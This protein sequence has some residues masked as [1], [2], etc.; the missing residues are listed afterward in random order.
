MNLIGC[1]CEGDERLLVAEF[2]PNE[3]LAKHLFHCKLAIYGLI[4][5]SAGFCL[6]TYLSRVRLEFGCPNK[7]MLGLVVS[8]E[9]DK[10]FCLLRILWRH[11]VLY[12][13]L[14]SVLWEIASSGLTPRTCVS[15][16]HPLTG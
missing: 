8:V 4:V 10:K 15:T 12:A 6:L 13:N 9:T 7:S 14:E 11:N 2:M 16:A 3:T 5:C 1:C